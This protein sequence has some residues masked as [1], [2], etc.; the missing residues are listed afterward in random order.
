MY[1]NVSPS[2][3]SDSGIFKDSISAMGAVGG[4]A[5]VGAA[6]AAPPLLDTDLND[7]NI[8]CDESFNTERLENQNSADNLRQSMQRYLATKHQHLKMASEQLLNNRP[9]EFRQTLANLPPYQPPP[10]PM[11][12]NPS[13]KDHK[14]NQQPSTNENAKLTKSHVQDDMEKPGNNNSTAKTDNSSVDI[15]SNTSNVPAQVI[16][17]PCDQYPSD[18]GVLKTSSSSSSRPLSAQ[19]NGGVFMGNLKPKSYEESA[20][21]EIDEDTN[22][23]RPSKPIN[24]HKI[25]LPKFLRQ[26]FAIVRPTAARKS[27]FSFFCH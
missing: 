12:Q 15:S 24:N 2:S 4:G 27:H 5:V 16:L 9:S 26:Y 19:S 8:V 11:L 22:K 14:V 1:E 10:K 13:L 7:V 21:S 17:K 3:N 25:D 23:V 20:E 18:P 6:A